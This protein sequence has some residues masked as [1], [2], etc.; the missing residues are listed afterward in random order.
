[1]TN[2]EIGKATSDLDLDNF[3]LDRECVLKN[4]S[5]EQTAKAIVKQMLPSI[6]LRMMNLSETD[7]NHFIKMEIGKDK[8][9]LQE[10]EKD[11]YVEYVSDKFNEDI[12]ERC[13][14]QNLWSTGE[15]YKEKWKKQF[16]E[17]AKEID[18]RISALSKE[19]ATN[20]TQIEEDR[21][22]KVVDI[23][24]KRDREKRLVDLVWTENELKDGFDHFLIDQMEYDNEDVYEDLN[25]EVIK[26]VEQVVKKEASMI[27]KPYTTQEVESLENHSQQVDYSMKANT[28]KK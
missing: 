3:I 28:P 20:N 5:I 15:E 16:P 12:E 1:M 19:I 11:Y 18:E 22:K 7:K 8:D 21:K 4:N 14:N 9:I 27:L 26:K 10:K 17:K 25:L 23:N 13:L 2:V 24:S 6:Q